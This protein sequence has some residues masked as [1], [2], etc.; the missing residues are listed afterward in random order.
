[1]KSTSN[2]HFLGAAGTVTGSKYLI[3]LSDTRIL[4]D[5]GLFQGLK[6]L[7]ELNWSQ[8]PV[9]A[10]SID[11][12][13]LTHGHL[14]HTGY[15]PRLY[16]T[17][18]E[19][20]VWGTSPT[21]DIAEIILRDSAKIQEEDAKRANEEG[22]SKNK[23][24]KPLYDTEDVEYSLTHFRDKE[25]DKWH[26]IA[27]DIKMRFRLNGHILGAAFIELQVKDK[28]LVFSGDVGRPGDHLLYDPE[29]PDNADIL[30]LESTYG[31]RL[32]SDEDMMVKLAKIVNDTTDRNGNL[33][34]PS[35]AVERAQL[36]MYMLWQLQVSKKIPSD[37]PVILDS[38]M[39]ANALSV[40]R[41]YPDWHKL[42]D[43]DV[44]EMIQN[45]RIVRS[46]KE[47]WE[48][49]DSPAPKIVIAGSGM[50]TGGRVLTYLKQYIDRPETT[51]LLAG[52]QAEGT[53][54]R[55]LLSGTDEIKFYGKYHPV[56]ARIE[57]LN[58]LSAHADKNELLDWVSDIHQSPEKVYLIHGEP[59]SLDMMRVKIRDTYGWNAEIPELFQ[60]DKIL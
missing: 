55:Q 42:T 44:D 9:K 11:L 23:P 24:A 28:L 49:I 33:I 2:I 8:L 14:D 56:K 46:F 35:F 60:I 22:F 45:T 15:L 58:G 34:I 5:C 1:M 19:G 10:S 52:F 43:N 30:F 29:K 36:L 7:R 26:S 21:M 50:V 47:T 20:D 59:Q 12:V 17:G 3:E 39:G 51:V 57:I 6:R 31:D 48:I 37:V 54:G 38:P 13:L 32:H 41:K 4:I 18:F 27:P 25:I 53:R 16:K 40:F